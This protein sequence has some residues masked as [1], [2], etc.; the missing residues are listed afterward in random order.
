M[1]E[2]GEI[3]P[4]SDGA[5]LKDLGTLV[6]LVLVSAKEGRRLEEFLE[7]REDEA[8]VGVSIGKEAVVPLQLGGYTVM[9]V[10][11]VRT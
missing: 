7:G 9:N 1:E 5:F 3:T 6:P 2:E 11:L 4:S 8:R 10:K